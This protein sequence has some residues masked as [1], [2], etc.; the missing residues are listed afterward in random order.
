[1]KEKTLRLTQV[2]ILLSTGDLFLKNGPTTDYSLGKKKCRLLLMNYSKM[3]SNVKCKRKNRKFKET[4][5]EYLHNAEVGK[6]FLNQ[7]GSQR[8]HGFDYIQVS[9]Y[10][11][12]ER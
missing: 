9:N 1:M 6:S 3:N 5:N 7:I 10:S 2:Y 12:N 4:T 8:S 11:Y